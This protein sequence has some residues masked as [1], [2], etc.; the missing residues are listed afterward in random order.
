MQIIPDN[1]PQVH[2]GATYVDLVI[3]AL[4]RWPDRQAIV[5]VGG[6]KLTYRELGDRILRFASTLE[7][8]ELKVGDGLAQ[9]ASNRADAFVTMVAAL[10]L[11]VR[12]TPLHPMGSLE[13]Q[14]YI[15]KDADVSLLVVDCPVFAER[16]RELCSQSSDKVKTVSLGDVDY[17]ENLIDMAEQADTAVAAPLPSS[18]DIAWLAYTGGTTGKP[19]GVIHTQNSMAAT[20]IVSEAEWE[21]PQEIRYLACSPISHAAGFLVV[22]TL[23]RGGSVYL[24]PGFDPD[25]VIDLVEFEGINTLFLVPTMIY[26]LLDYPRTSEA[27]LSNLD[28][29]IYASAPMS[30]TRLQ[31]AIHQ[32]GPVMMQCYGQTESIHL[33]F[34]GRADHDVTRQERF[35]SCGRAPA[36]NLVA[37]LDENGDPLPQGD[38]GEVCA[39]GA[40]IMLGYWNQPEATAEVFRNGW[41]H[42]GDLGYQDEDGFIYLVDRVKDMIISGGFNV[43]SKEVEDAL[44]DHPDVAQ[45]A[46]IGAPD[47][48]WGEKV[49]AVVKRREDT[50]TDQEL[51]ALVKEKKGAVHA[52]KQVEF[53]EEIPLTSLGKVDK[54]ALR[55]QFW[56]DQ[57]RMVN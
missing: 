38:I 35:L 51:M 40:T 12:Y 10:R 28:T 13:D 14:L 17:A 53:V 22:P 43:Y 36:G 23:L 21:W 34:M 24:L 5:D 44:V 25:K 46:V 6:L 11:G 3:Q 54:N 56:T 20:A 26:V 30:P 18:N 48:K 8:L 33:T 4:A 1:Y 49:V 57:T 32:F 7:S 2:Q 47:E 31:D 19:K 9:L 16:G 37:I 29:L 15:L 41:L 45:C 52:P 55:G 42:T 27:D 50:V 39:R